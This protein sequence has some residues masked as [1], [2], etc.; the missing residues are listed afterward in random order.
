MKRTIIVFL[1]LFALTF[2]AIPGRAMADE[3]IKK[4]LLKNI[5]GLWTAWQKYN[6]E[7]F[8]K[9]QAPDGVTVT[10]SGATNLND[11]L[12]QLATKQCQVKSF[13]IDEAG[14]TV[15]KIDAN[16]YVII[17]KAEQ[18]A[19]CGGV[20]SPSPVMVSEVWSKSNG[21]WQVHH[22]Q[23]TALASN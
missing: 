18:D 10:S 21:N 16:T 5:N 20:K 15:K 19:T 17:Y 11:F 13:S 22:Y 12:Q 8:K 3:S 1:C 6:P 23:E 4:E 14:A 9:W 7:P 2:A